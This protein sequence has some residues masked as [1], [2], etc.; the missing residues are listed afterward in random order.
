MALLK[1]A[2]I[3][4]NIFHFLADIPAYA[5]I[6]YINLTQVY[7]PQD[8]DDWEQFLLKHGWL[9]LL[10]ARFFIAVYDIWIRMN[11]KGEYLDENG[12][13]QKKSVWSVVMTIFKSFIR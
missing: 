8:Y 4:D 13:S 6:A 3:K 12:K 1:D 11:N 9:I 2:V 5:C 10:S 7:L